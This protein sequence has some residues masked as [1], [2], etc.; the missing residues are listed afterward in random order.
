MSKLEYIIWIQVIIICVLSFVIYKNSRIKYSGKDI[1]SIYNL[2]LSYRNVYIFLV[3]L[4]LLLNILMIHYSSEMY[5]IHE[6]LR[7][8]WY[9]LVPLCG[10]LVLYMMIPKEV[11]DD[12]S[13]KSQPNMIKKR[14]L[15][16]IHILLIILLVSSILI[17]VVNVPYFGFYK[18][19]K[20]SYLG[21]SRILTLIIVI[22]LTIKEKNM[23]NCRY[24]LPKNWA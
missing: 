3:Y 6:S 19:K 8:Y 18:N 7:K 9:Y 5:S 13:F 22:Y 23:S 12:G 20:L 17:E 1:I 15:Y 2:K 14:N 4:V 21:M 11:V 10:I 24:G 16:R